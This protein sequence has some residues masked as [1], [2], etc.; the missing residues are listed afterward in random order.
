VGLHDDAKRRLA[1]RWG[2]QVSVVECGWPQ[3]SE[4]VL[5]KERYSAVLGKLLCSA[6]T[7]WTALGTLFTDL[8]DSDR[9]LV[10]HWSCV[11]E[12]EK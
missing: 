9:A 12:A 3:L 6:R 7:D 2:M 4:D 8:S 10:I 5:L 11:W 1:Q